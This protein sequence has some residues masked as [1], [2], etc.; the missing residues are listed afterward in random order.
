MTAAEIDQLVEQTL[1]TLPERISGNEAN[2]VVAERLSGIAVSSRYSLVEYLRGLISFRVRDSERVAADAIRE[3]GIWMAL[4]L[5]EALSLQE[6]RPDIESLIR[7]IRDGAIFKPV[8]ENMVR[9]YLS[10]IEPLRSNPP[11]G[12]R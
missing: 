2:Q 10:R 9:R 12:P 11:S 5:T 3:A 4:D 6:L 7:D 1:A 8:H